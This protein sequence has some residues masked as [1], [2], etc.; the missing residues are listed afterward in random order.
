MDACR[1]PG[2]FL[3]LFPPILPEVEGIHH[4][5]IPG[6]ALTTAVR[7]LLFSFITPGQC[8]ARHYCGLVRRQHHPETDV[9]RPA[10]LG[11]HDLLCRRAYTIP[12]SF[13]SGD[14][15]RSDPVPFLLIFGSMLLTYF[16]FSKVGGW[17]EL[18]AYSGQNGGGRSL[19]QLSRE[20]GSITPKRC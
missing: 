20:C 13:N 18:I 4:A 10:D 8:D 12:G 14:T 3:H 19:C 16:A 5:G 17:S 7:A 11:H 15:D 6:A 2:V 9:S 1:H